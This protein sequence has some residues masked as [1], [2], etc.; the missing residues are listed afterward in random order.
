MCIFFD[1]ARSSKDSRSSV[2][3]CPY[4]ITHIY[5]VGA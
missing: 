3:D 4:S 5:S 2:I 1:R